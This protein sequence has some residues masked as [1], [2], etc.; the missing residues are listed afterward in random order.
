MPVAVV[1]T[2]VG[3]VLL[4]VIAV[5]CV[6]YVTPVRKAVLE[7]ALP[8]VRGIFDMHTIINGGASLEK[9]LSAIRILESYIEVTD[10]FY[11][12]FRDKEVHYELA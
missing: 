11:E 9:S 7:K 3:V 8:V 12:G 5:G 1:G 6:L 10:I 2:A 4:A